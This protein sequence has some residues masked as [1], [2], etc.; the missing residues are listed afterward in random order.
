MSDTFHDDPRV[1]TIPALVADRAAQLGDKPAIVGPDEDGSVHRMGYREL[2]VRSRAVAKALVARGIERGDRVA[3]WAPNIWEWVVLSY[4]IQ[5]AGAAVVPINTRYRGREAAYLLRRSGARALFTVTG[6]LGNDY[7]ALLRAAG[8]PSEETPALQHVVVVRGERPEGTV[9]LDDFL[10]AGD[11]VDDATLDA[12]IATIRPEDYAEVSFTSGT[13]GNPKGVVATHEQWS[14]PFRAWVDVTGLVAAD[15]VVVIAPFFHSFGSKAGYFTALLAGA[16][17]YPLVTFDPG[18]ALRLIEAERISVIPGPPAIFQ[19]LLARPD[20]TDHDLS[21]LRLAVTGSANVPVELVVAMRDVLRFDRVVTGYG[22]TEASGIATMCRHD[23]DPET[24]ARTAGRAVPGVELRV[25][26]PD[27]ATLPPGQD[28]EVV[29][30]G[31]NVMSGYW[32]DP[33]AT[34]ATIKDGWL[35]T[36]DIGRLDERGNLT[37]TDRLKDMFIV[38]GFNVYPAEVEN[39]LG[40]HPAVAQAAVIGVPDERLGDVGMAFVVLRP[41][42]S[43]GEAELLDWARGEVANFKVPRYVHIVDTLPRNASEKVLK[44]A[45]RREAEA[46]LAQRRG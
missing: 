29:L 18:E 27:G 31:Y 33:D 8:D 7:V 43:V 26:G 13:T 42:A 28:G 6:F 37:I 9:G 34:A 2:E 32:E 22:L 35:H 40:R 15:R 23:D 21:S 10:R 24:I 39:L 45:L 36:G 12:R 25:V 41:G 19:T 4:G 16:T 1:V 38:G 17:V 3:I 5:I 20:R 30:R 44:P 14:M 46:I 11:A